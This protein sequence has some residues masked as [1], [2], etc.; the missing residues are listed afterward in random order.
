M[1]KK[2][3]IE[4]AKAYYQY[5]ESKG[6]GIQEISVTE[7]IPMP[8]FYFKL[9]LSGKIR[10]WGNIQFLL[11]QEKKT[12]DIKKVK[13]LEYDADANFIIMKPLEDFSEKFLNL[14]PGNLKLI[15][16]MKFLIKKVQEWFE[17]LKKPLQIP[18]TESKYAT[19]WQSL[20]FLPGEKNQ[21]NQQQREALSVIFTKPFSY[22]WGPPGTG[23]TRFV[24]A[25]S[26]LHYI[27]N[28]DKV[29]ILA[30][31]NNAIEQVLE[32]VFEM[33]D[34]AGIERNK[35]I[36]LGLPTR[37]F[38]NKYPEVCEEK[39]A[40]RILA[41]IDVAL[42]KLERVLGIERKE[43]V[44]QAAGFITSLLEEIKNIHPDIDAITNEIT[45]LGDLK[46]KKDAE[47]S[48]AMA[49][50]K[51]QNRQKR[52][53]EKKA[54]SFLHS[55]ASMFSSGETGLQQEIRKC[56]SNIR[57]TER[58][59]E[60]LEGEAAGFGQQIFEKENNNKQLNKVINKKRAEIKSRIDQQELYELLPKVDSDKI[61]DVYAAYKEACIQLENEVKEDR[62]LAAEYATVDYMELSDKLDRLRAER[63]RLAAG[64]TGERIKKANVIACTLDAFIG[65]QTELE[66]N[67]HHIFLDEA[68]YAGLI[69]ALTLFQ[70][71][72]PITF[73]GDHMQLPPVCEIPDSTIER[74]PLYAN[75][76]LWAQS[77]VFTDSVFANSLDVCKM[78]YLR[79]DKPISEKMAI[80]RLTQTHRFGSKLSA[81][82]SRWVYKGEFTSANVSGTTKILTVDAPKDSAPI[83]RKSL[84][85]AGKIQ[86]IV[87]GLKEKGNLDFVVLSPYKKQLQE[88]QKKLPKEARELKILT[89]H[90]SQGREWDY[91]ILSVVDT[92]KMY[93]V[94][95]KNKRAKGLN[96]INTAVSRA[97]KGLILVCDLH[98]WQNQQGQLITDLIQAGSPVSV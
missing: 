70:H 4:S 28:G 48:K 38:A 94:D 51:E 30:P 15:S 29:L 60:K 98:F 10:D 13:I 9:I 75:V 93:F 82:L 80:S 77:A 3:C 92:D 22:I 2:A 50:I 44:F 78:E 58:K 66:L 14:I 73:L 64:S 97:R 12:F 42:K 95:S 35:I 90:G 41:E 59:K 27:S 1:L 39:G 87:T 19:N 18:T 69:K 5:L 91:V 86:K 31:T 17:N 6:E 52:E 63:E 61:A 85:E 25:Y 74:N 84:S 47:V 56:S 24:L 71:K 49:Y 33:T 23:K 11:V 16:D 7:I 79:N 62:M 46:K 21:P 96:L 72:C 53:L 65:R 57:A 55:L 83:K 40:Q 81:V 37:T 34:L 88:L 68:G 36:R 67:F 32:G 89:V 20:K 45:R 76:F 54:D 8:D 26:L 43:E